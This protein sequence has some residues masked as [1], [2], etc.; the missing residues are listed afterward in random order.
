M[1]APN[2]VWTP[3]GAREARIFAL[4]SGTQM[5]EP[6]SASATP[7]E[8]IQVSGLKELQLNDPEPQ[9]IFHMGDDGIFSVDA[10]PPTEAITG[11]VMTGKIAADLEAALTGNKVVTIGEMKGIGI[12][13]NNKGSE[14]QVGMYFYRQAQDTQPG[15]LTFGARRW[16]FIVFPS[17][18]LIPLEPGMGGTDFQKA[19][20]LRPQITSKHLW[21]ITYTVATDGFTRAQGSKWVT[22]YKPR[23]V[24]WK[25][26]NVLTQFNLPTDYPAVS[27]DKMNI[28]VFDASAGTV[29]DDTSGATLTTTTVDPS[30]T[31][32]VDDIVICVFEH[33]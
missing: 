32:D 13:T 1:A 5:I 23:L 27:T 9:Q 16:E 25:G 15:S 24:A 17:V 20:T 12:G 2:P 10:L 6:G 8:G 14:I 33:A 28:F 21:G 4:D 31:P 7:Y 3:V 18:L 30:T 19:Y 11:S 29:S 22:Q 26:N